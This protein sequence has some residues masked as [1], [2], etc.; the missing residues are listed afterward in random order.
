MIGARLSLATAALAAGFGLAACTDVEEADLATQCLLENDVP[1]A[2]AYDVEKAV[3]LV[4]PVD[5]GTAEGAAILNACIERKA[6][7]A[8][9]KPKPLP[10]SRPAP[11]PAP[12][13][14]PPKPSNAV[15]PPGAPFL[16]KGVYCGR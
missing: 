4:T 14:A 3:P 11:A 12:E 10:Q 7:M 2:Y 8:A 6:A 1:G 16:Y 15:C 5:D 13:P 9:A